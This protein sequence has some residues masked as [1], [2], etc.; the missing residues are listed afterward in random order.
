MDYID[1][2][3]LQR[4]AQEE[5]DEFIKAIFSLIVENESGVLSRVIGLFAGRGYNIES[6]TVAPVD[7]HGRKSRINILTSGT[8]MVINQIKEQL[9]KQVPV[10]QVV[11]LCQHGPYVAREL[12]LIKVVSKGSERAEALNLADAFR[13]QVVD[14]SVDSLVFELTGKTEKIDAFVDLL[15]PLGLV[16]LSRTGIAAIGRG[17]QT[18]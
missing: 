9:N 7:D 15:R 3:T 4:S 2:K 17:C 16:E 6:L 18:I 13:A 11:N 12:A 8:P 5:K 1:K 14:A 10:Y